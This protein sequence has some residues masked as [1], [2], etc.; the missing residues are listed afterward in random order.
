[1][2]RLKGSPF[3]QLAAKHKTIFAKPAIAGLV[4]LLALVIALAIFISFTSLDSFISTTQKTTV[5]SQYG[6]TKQVNADSLSSKAKLYDVSFGDTKNPDLI[7][8]TKGDSIEAGNHLYKA[9]FAKTSDKALVFSIDE[10]YIAYTPEGLKTKNATVVE[11]KVTYYDVAINTDLERVVTSQGLKQNYILSAP[12]HP[13]SFTEKID[14]NLSVKLQADGSLIYYE[15]SA[16]IASKVIAKSPKPHL[17]DA[18]GKVVWL[19]Y[20]LLRDKLTL[21]LPSLK[22]LSYPITVDLSVFIRGSQWPF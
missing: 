13:N 16:A 17:T 7:L 6:A 18:K 22:G 12:G 14:S 2:A 10:D 4:A 5:N 3:D 21:K 1:M 20:A 9:S 8:K 19:S 11:N 15:G